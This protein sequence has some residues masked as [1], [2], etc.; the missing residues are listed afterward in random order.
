MDER[1]SAVGLVGLLTVVIGFCCG[2][3]LL[4]S[5]GAMG[6]VSGFVV[7]SWQLLAASLAV[8]GAGVFRWRQHAETRCES[9]VAFKPPVGVG[10]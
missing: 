4:T 2:L 10:R 6:A 9:L 7:G 5:I 8:A 1:E 3:P